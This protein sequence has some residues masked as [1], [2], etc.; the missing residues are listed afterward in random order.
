MTLSKNR[1]SRS[2]ANAPF[3]SGLAFEC[4]RPR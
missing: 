1:A 4:K 2:A 3:P